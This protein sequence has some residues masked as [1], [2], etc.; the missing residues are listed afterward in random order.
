MKWGDVVTRLYGKTKA[1]TNGAS[2]AADASGDVGDGGGDVTVSDPTLVYLGVSTD[3]GAYYYGAPEPGKSM[4][5]VLMQSITR[6][7]GPFSRSF[8]LTPYVCSSHC[9]LHIHTLNT[10]YP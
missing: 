10:P 2:A 8:S 6:K 3:N 4:E 1:N 5:Q 9:F 7:V